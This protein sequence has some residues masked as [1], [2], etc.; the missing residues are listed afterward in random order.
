MDTA[1][2]SEIQAGM[3]FD[4]IGARYT[5]TWN[6]PMEPKNLLFI[7]SDQH[8]RDTLGGYGHPQVRTPNLDGLAKQGVRFTNAYCNCPISVPSRASLATGRYVHQTGNW[9]NAF[10]YHGTVRGWGHRLIEQ[11][12]TVASIGK[13]H[14]RNAEDDD[15]FSQKILPLNV[16]DG[17]GD[18]IGAVRDDPPPRPGMRTGIL[19]A[20]PGQSTYLDY[21]AQIS[22]GACQWLQ[23]QAQTGGG[24]TKPWVFFVSFVCPHPPFIAPPH[25]YDS[26][27]LNQI[28][29]PAQ[30]Q[31]NEQPNHSALNTI[32][33]VMNYTSPFTE[34]Q[35]RN[36][37]AAYYGTCTYLDEQ[38]GKVL[39]TLRDTGLAPSTRIIYTSDHGE[40]MGRRG[41]WGK[42]TH[43]EESAAVPFLM[44]GPGLPQGATCEE[45]VSLVDCH[46]TIIDAV[47]GQHTPEYNDLPGDS[48]FGVIA[49]QSTGRT[50]FSEYHATGSTRASYMIRNGNYKYIHYIDAPPQL[51]DLAK[52]PDELTN[53]ADNAMCKQITANLKRL[54]YQIIDPDVI[55]E[56]AR[57]D[58]RA[59]LDRHGGR[60]AV[61]S[62][63]A[64]VNSPVPGEKPIFCTK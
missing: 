52:D 53:L 20:G 63:G 54:L 48:L 18:L 50:A 6:L 9:D 64:F 40:S 47:G 44:A 25:L 55:D 21:D 16:Y 22:K 42:F 49:G 61:L 39:S 19:E 29:L 11:G 7:L 24:H 2:V 1:L 28:G 5:F 60:D 14:Y 62:R 56:Q 17:V 3:P 57:S 12:H 33:R 43:Y 35:I 31:L 8:N 27:P 58:Q 46:P 23:R 51:F 15:G 32:R 37:T 38:V 13:L 59:L 4:F 45:I 41:L 34:Q 26:Y 10:P 36:V 30:N